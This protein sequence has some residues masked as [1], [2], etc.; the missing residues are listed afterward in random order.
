MEVSQL[1]GRPHLGTEGIPL[2]WGF[3][4]WEWGGRGSHF[5]EGP[6]LG[7]GGVPLGW[8]VSFLKWG[9]S[10]FGGVPFG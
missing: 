5:E 2:G 1:D 6:I 10:H 3:P 9:G 8:E 4:F 7:V